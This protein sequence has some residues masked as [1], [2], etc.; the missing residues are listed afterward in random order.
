MSMPN[1][2]MPTA[3]NGPSSGT[4][5]PD[6]GT[7]VIALRSSTAFGAIPRSLWIPSAETDLA[8][9]GLTDAPRDHAATPTATEDTAVLVG[10]CLWTARQHE[11]YLERARV[12]NDGR[13]LHRY[14]AILVETLE[15]YAEAGDPTCRL[16]LGWLA[17]KGLIETC[18][19]RSSGQGV[20]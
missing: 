20:A 6:H 13:T 3:Q 7:N 19:P 2:S 1:S 16:V 15:R 12:T 4:P 8:L 9:P 5:R 17:R 14:P 10:L 18:L 11:G